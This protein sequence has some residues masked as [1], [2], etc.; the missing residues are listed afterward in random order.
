MSDP[1]LLSEGC[2]N[3][4]LPSNRQVPLLAKSRH[5]MSFSLILPRSRSK[6]KS[7]RPYVNYNK[8]SLYYYSKIINLSIIIKLAILTIN[9]IWLFIILYIKNVPLFYPVI[10]FQW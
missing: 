10:Q 5:R 3:L 4:Q 8:L 9:K 2:L 6:N 1:P 7:K